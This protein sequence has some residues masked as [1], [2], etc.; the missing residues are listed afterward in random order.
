MPKNNESGNYR[1]IT[2]TSTN[3]GFRGTW[4][5]RHG[6]QNELSMAQQGIG[7][8][9]STHPGTI[10]WTRDEGKKLTKADK[11]HIAFAI[12]KH[13]GTNLFDEEV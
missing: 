2:C 6:T 12:L 3:L 1:E 4:K 8:R 11:S 9:V 10:L 13:S 7:D 5:R